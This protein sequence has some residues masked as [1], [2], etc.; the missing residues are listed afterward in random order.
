MDLTGIVQNGV[1]VLENAP[2]LKEGTRV[3]VSVEPSKEEC[4]A[5]REML[6]EHA[7]TA[8][9]LPSDMAEQHDHYIHGTPKR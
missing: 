8:K 7:G 6:L 1:I 5:L 4:K 3:R 9:G 2:P